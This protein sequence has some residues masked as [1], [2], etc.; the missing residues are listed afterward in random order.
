MD[1]ISHIAN[2]YQLSSVVQL[3]VTYP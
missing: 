1:S 3:V 2:D